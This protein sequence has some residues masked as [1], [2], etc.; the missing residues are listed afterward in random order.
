MKKIIVLIALVIFSIN[1]VNALN[2]YYD[3][4][5]VYNKGNLSYNSLNVKPLIEGGILSDNYEGE[6]LLRLISLNNTLLYSTYFDI[7]LEIIYDTIDFREDPNH[8]I[9]FLD[10][11]EIN[12]KTPYYKNAKEIIIYGNGSDELLKIDLLPYSK[13]KCGNYICDFGESY[14]TCKRDCRSGSKDDYCDKIKDNKCDPDCGISLDQ[15]C[16][17]SGIIDKS[18]LNNQDLTIGLI[19]FIIILVLIIAFFMIKRRVK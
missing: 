10:N 13:Q 19:I 7:N 17:N 15:D 3:F 6:Y 14:N 12:I 8:G 4:N 9:L 1:L 2:N 5:L 11:T 18:K 16:L